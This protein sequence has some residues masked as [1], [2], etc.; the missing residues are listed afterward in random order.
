M[1]RKP[2]PTR[3]I[4]SLEPLEDRLCLSLGFGWAD[5]AGSA[6]DP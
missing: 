6:L 3:R 5:R 2:R 1:M 4:L